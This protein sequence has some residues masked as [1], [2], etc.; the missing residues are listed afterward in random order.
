MNRSWFSHSSEEFPLHGSVSMNCSPLDTLMLFPW[1]LTAASLADPRHRW[2][3][4]LATGGET[5]QAAA[6][7]CLLP[8]FKQRGIFT[9]LCLLGE[10]GYDERRLPC[11]STESVTQNVCALPLRWETGY[12]V[13]SCCNTSISFFVHYCLRRRIA[14]TGT[15]AK[16]KTAAAKV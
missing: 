8:W 2:P 1:G 11:E 13:Q 16:F 7:F 5:C 14:G 15:A 4:W 9:G 10:V 12:P 3:A 6:R